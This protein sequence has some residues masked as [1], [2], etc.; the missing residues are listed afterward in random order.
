MKIPA[1]RLLNLCTLVLLLVSL[2]LVGCQGQL[3][4]DLSFGDGQDSGGGDVG[5][6]LSN[7]VVLLVLLIVVLALALG[8]R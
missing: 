6:A 3:G 7:P 5:Q 1:M 2:L 8:R 4:L